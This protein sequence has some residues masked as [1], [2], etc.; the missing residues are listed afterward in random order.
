[1]A[2]K[3]LQEQYS[4][5]LVETRKAVEVN[6]RTNK[7]KVYKSVDSKGDV[8]WF[9]GTRGAI[10]ICRTNSS[11]NSMDYERLIKPS[12]ERWKQTKEK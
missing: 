6:S 5:F 9:L 11:T 8:Y 1:M 7:Y 10:R 3:T 4:E 12:F 2:R